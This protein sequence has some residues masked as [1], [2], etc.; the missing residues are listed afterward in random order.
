[1]KNQANP[2]KDYNLQVTQCEYSHEPNHL[3]LISQ[4]PENGIRLFKK[5]MDTTIEKTGCLQFSHHKKGRE[6]LLSSDNILKE[7]LKKIKFF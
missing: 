3:M 5:K 2:S 4:M 6:I 7:F 1:M